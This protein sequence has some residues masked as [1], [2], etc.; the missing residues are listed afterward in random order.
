MVG[1]IDWSGNV[2][3]NHHV[4]VREPLLYSDFLF[5]FKFFD[6]VFLKQLP[7]RNHEGLPVVGIGGLCYSQ[8]RVD[9]VMVCCVLNQVF[10]QA[11]MLLNQHKVKARESDV[12]LMG[13][14]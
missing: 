10:D 11:V 9:N 14:V 13:L 3:E 1:E 2:A 7:H 8:E 4:Y 12:F 6:M 5:I